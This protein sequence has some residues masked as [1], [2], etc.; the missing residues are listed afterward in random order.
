M[1]ATKIDPSPSSEISRFGAISDPNSAPGAVNFDRIVEDFGAVWNEPDPGERRRRIQTVWRADGWTCN[2][3]LPGRGYE[4]IERRVNI[5]RE[6]WLRDGKHLFKRDKTAGHHDVVRDDF[7]V[8]SIPEDKVEAHGLC[9]LILDGHGRLQADLHFNPA[10]DEAGDFVNFYLAVFNEADADRQRNL[11][12][13]L[14]APD[15]TYVRELSVTCGHSS[16]LR[17]L[18]QRQTENA[19]AE[20]V[21]VPANASQAH[22]NFVTFRWRLENRRSGELSESGSELVILDESGRIRTDYQFVDPA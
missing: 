7:V 11:L 9:F 20:L 17:G 21:F 2:K 5:S 16:L 22:H 19:G 3:V 15:A 10:V 18:R 8:V 1:N 12:I 6:K 4:Q 14:W 13:D